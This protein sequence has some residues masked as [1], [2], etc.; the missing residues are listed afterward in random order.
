MNLILFLI[1]FLID[2]EIHMKLSTTCII[3]RTIFHFRF[4]PVNLILLLTTAIKRSQ[5]DMFVSSNSKFSDRFYQQI[6]ITQS[7]SLILLPLARF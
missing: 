5:S 2:R 7:V 1:D 3:L 6:S 4:Q